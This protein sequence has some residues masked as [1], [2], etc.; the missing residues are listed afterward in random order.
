MFVSAAET[1]TEQS[2]REAGYD[3]GRC[4]VSYTFR[5]P[6]PVLNIDPREIIY[7]VDGADETWFER[8]RILLCYTMSKL[9]EVREDGRQFIGG[10]VYACDIA[11]E[12]CAFGKLDWQREMRRNLKC[13]TAGEYQ[14]I[15]ATLYF[16]QFALW[17]GKLLQ[18]AWITYMRLGRALYDQPPTY[19]ECW[20][21]FATRHASPD[22]TTFYGRVLN[23]LGETL[24]PL[25][26][27]DRNDV[28]ANRIW[29]FGLTQMHKLHSNG[30]DDPTWRESINRMIDFGTL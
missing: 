23:Y 10:L 5:M 21:D 28:S 8:R 6:R 9:A 29:D 30:L 14:H 12:Q 3:V 25:L 16:A 11:I 15:C 22:R 7:Q 18:E 17:I 2:L 27:L 19:C 13:M 24:N 4:F 1:P 20:I 26:L